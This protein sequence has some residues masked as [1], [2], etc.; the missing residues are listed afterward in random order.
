MNRTCIAAYCMIE[1]LFLLAQTSPAAAAQPAVKAAADAPYPTRPIRVVVPFPAGTSPNDI[2]ARL[3]G[4]KLAEGLRQQVVIDNRPGA[5]GIIGS[6][7]VAKSAPDGYTLLVNSITLAIAPNAYKNMPF[8]VARD[9]QPITMVAS[10]PM[11]IM[12]SP[13]LP[14]NSI[15]DLIAYAKAKP[16]QIKFG[17]GGNGNVS[18]LAGEMLNYLAGIQMTHIPY[19]GGA[20]AAAALL[21]G[22]ISMF[23]DTPTA[24]LGLI[25]ERKVKVLAVASMKRTSLLPEVPTTGEAGLPG[26][27]MHVWYGYFAPARTPAAVLQT[28]HAEL[29]RVLQSAEIQSRFAAM[30]TETV[31]MAPDEFTRVFRADVHKWAK[32]IRETGLK[33]D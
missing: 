22:E 11:Q 28:L 18:H 7:I 21:G 12:I 31:G 13:A 26:Y 25:K 20:P 17:S 5:S 27:D 29:A 2:T 14:A 33:L 19:K 3:I 32:F 1:V 16:G 4:P 6:D 30:G 24:W 23:I 15:R 9:L 8:D 10:A